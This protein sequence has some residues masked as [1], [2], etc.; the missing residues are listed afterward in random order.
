METQIQIVLNVTTDRHKIFTKQTDNEVLLFLTRLLQK[1]SKGVNSFD[2]S[3]KNEK[4]MRYTCYCTDIFPVE[5]AFVKLQEGN[6]QHYII[7]KKQAEL[8]RWSICFRALIGDFLPK[9]EYN[10]KSL[11]V[12]KNGLIKNVLNILNPIDYFH[13]IASFYSKTGVVIKV[14]VN[15]QP[16][17]KK[18]IA[19]SFTNAK[20]HERIEKKF[21]VSF[22]MTET[23][24]TISKKEPKYANR[25]ASK[26]PFVS[27]EDIVVDFTDHS[28][29]FEGVTF[30]QY[31]DSDS[32]LS[33]E[34]SRDSKIESSATKNESEENVSS[35]IATI[36]ELA[37]S[38]LRV[39]ASE[40]AESFLHVPA[41][42]LA[43]PFLQVQ[44]LSKESDIAS[45]ETLATAP[46]TEAVDNEKDELMRVLKDLESENSTLYETNLSIKGEI[47]IHKNLYSKLVEKQR[48]K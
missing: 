44:K 35:E 32:V 16:L 27:V 12:E 14:V 36:S 19:G 37:E 4:E 28:S 25:Q 3:P 15:E 2:V 11:K 29:D 21:G 43:E 1:Q 40:L 39:P 13:V 17:D 9:L 20:F 22:K 10:Y 23:A 18:F 33:C 24:L 47:V 38:F 7:V 45:F 31:S 42:E 48:N 34:E 5:Q 8:F 46:S 6:Y 26:V 30:E 41:S